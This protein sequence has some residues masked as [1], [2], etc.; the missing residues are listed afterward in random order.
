M[1]TLLAA[2]LLGQNWP[3]QPKQPVWVTPDKVGITINVAF[4]EEAKAVLRD[5]QA[6]MTAMRQEAQAMRKETM[7][8]ARW[9]AGWLLKILVA[10]GLVLVLAV[11][12]VRALK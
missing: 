11:V 12:I 4:P 6:T 10:L 5:A 9:F 2:L 1:T 8:L 3:A 7:E